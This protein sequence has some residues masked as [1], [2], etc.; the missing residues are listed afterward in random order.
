MRHFGGSGGI[1]AHAFEETGRTLRGPDKCHV[2]PFISHLTANS[3]L[4][5]AFDSR[6]DEMLVVNPTLPRV[7]TVKCA[8]PSAT[9]KRVGWCHLGTAGWLKDNFSYFCEVFTV[10]VLHFF[11]LNNVVL[12]VFYK[13]NLLFQ[14][15]QSRVM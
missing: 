9:S 13:N 6:F 12:F 15:A 10:F 2:F 3:H 4:L 7:S 8:E 1:R 11:V 14:F 5:R